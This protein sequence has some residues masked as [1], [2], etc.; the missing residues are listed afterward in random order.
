MSQ[1]Y[2]QQP[3]LHQTPPVAREELDA[4]LEQARE[5]ITSLQRKKDELERAKGELEEMR[6]RH[7]EFARGRVEIVEALNRGL[8]VLEHEQVETQRMADLIGRT[9]QTFKE[10]LSQVEGLTDANWSSENLKSELSK[11]LA[12]IETAR[13]EFN[14]ACL[15]IDVLQTK[16]PDDM[17][18]T[19]LEKFS[20]PANP[21]ER[22][23]FGQAMKLGFAFS[24]PLVAVLLVLV[25]TLLIKW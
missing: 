24:L 4:T 8:V 1:N 5:Q 9:R 21:L 11:A 19:P 7:D 10:Q 17:P 20:G 15:R 12:L 16:S 23:S 3:S 14:R 22:I 2:P 13:M 6:R 18:Q 25:L